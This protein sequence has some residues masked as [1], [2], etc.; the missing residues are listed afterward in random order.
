M[1]HN[2]PVAV[3]DRIVHIVRDNHRHEV[4][5]F[6]QTVAQGQNLGG[7]GCVFLTAAGGKS[8]QNKG[9]TKN[10]IYNFCELFYVF[11]SV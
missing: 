7:G 11:T 1:H 9:K 4:V 5:F 10:D 2:Q 6:D 3:N 8:R